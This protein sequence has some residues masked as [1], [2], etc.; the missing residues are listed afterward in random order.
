MARR[1]GQN[2]KKKKYLKKK[3]KKKRHCHLAVKFGT[4]PKNFS[5]PKLQLLVSVLGLSLTKYCT[6][7]KID[8]KITAF[9]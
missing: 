8:K 7:R 6:S 1:K 2:K 4:T 5:P 3:K 9:N